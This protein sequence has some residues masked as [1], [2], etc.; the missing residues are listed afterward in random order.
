MDRGWDHVARQVRIHLADV[1]GIG[2]H[3]ELAPAHAQQMVLAHQP[4][5]PLRVHPPPAF[6]Q[7][8]GN[9]RPPVSR[10]LHGDLLDRVA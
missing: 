6:A 2:G 5:D 10:P 7:F 3:D 4:V 1:V 8:A 9:A